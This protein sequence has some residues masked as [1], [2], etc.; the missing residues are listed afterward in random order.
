MLQ[1]IVLSVDP[2]AEG[3]AATEW[4]AENLE[5]GTT[6]VAVCGVS[7]VGE[8]MIGLPLFEEAGDAHELHQQFETRWIAPLKTAGF[9]CR[10]RFGLDE[11]AGAVREVVDEEH[12]DAVVVG[13]AAHNGLKE[14]LL[15]GV[16]NALVHHM[17]CPVILVPPTLAARS[18]R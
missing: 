12:P 5:P 15:P 14:H 17:P 16:G 10:T 1:K 9:D 18:P 3:R 8:F 11:S 6:I 2:S 13:K 7:D 4:C